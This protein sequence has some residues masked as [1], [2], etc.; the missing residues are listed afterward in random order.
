MARGSVWHLTSWTGWR[1]NSNSDK[2]E[3]D[4]FKSDQWWANPNLEWFDSLKIRFGSQQLGFDSVFFC[5]SIWAVRFDR[6]II[7]VLTHQSFSVFSWFAC[8]V[9]W[10]YSATMKELAELQPSQ[11]ALSFTV[12]S[13]V[14]ARKIFCDISGRSKRNILLLLSGNS[15]CGRFDH[16]V[17]AASSFHRDPWLSEVHD[18]IWKVASGAPVVGQFLSKLTVALQSCNI[19]DT[20]AERNNVMNATIN[21]WSSRNMK[22]I[23]GVR[24]HYFDTMCK[25]PLQRSAWQCHL[26]KYIV[27]NNNNN[28]KFKLV[29]KTAAFRHFVNDTRQRISQWSVR[30]L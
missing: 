16:R 29:A 14:K 8:W 5:D 20:M 2:V 26:N 24:F 11:P 10:F 30:E 17:H 1:H 13:A 7:A 27:N 12:T 15:R 6:R 25:V 4:T 9:N 19:Q 18:P 21:L 22:P 23:I 28:D 3:N